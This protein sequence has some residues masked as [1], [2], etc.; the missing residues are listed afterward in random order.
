MGARDDKRNLAQ[1]Y[2]WSKLSDSNKASSDSGRISWNNFL[3]IASSTK[4]R[5]FVRV[6]WEALP[7]WAQLNDAKREVKDGG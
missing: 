3:L 2:V 4:F 1:V 5:C 7:G 6:L